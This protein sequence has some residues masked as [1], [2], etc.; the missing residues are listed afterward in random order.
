MK[1]IEISEDE[2]DSDVEQLINKEERNSDLLLTWA[3]TKPE[4][5]D[6][7]KTFRNPEDFI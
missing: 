7:M 5:K 1:R 6:D 3:P 4:E 2:T